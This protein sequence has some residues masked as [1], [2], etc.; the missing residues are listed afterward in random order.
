MDPCGLLTAAQR[1]RF[2]LG[3]GSRSQPGDGDE[4]GSLDC[5]WP[6]SSL[7][8]FGGPLVRLIVKRGAQYYLGSTQAVQVVM[9]AGFSAV[10][11]SSAYLDPRSI[12]WCWSM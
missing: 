12:V 11:T 7:A 5:L 8:P 3:A 9:I 6:K 2:G 4:F 1:T 10:Q